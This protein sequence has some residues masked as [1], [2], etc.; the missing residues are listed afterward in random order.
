MPD[1]FCFIMQI[2]SRASKNEF[3]F[4]FK[5]LNTDISFIK[6]PSNFQI[7]SGMAL[8]AICAFERKI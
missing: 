7:F 1:R 8:S 2:F 5:Q 3:Y 6:T 4:Y